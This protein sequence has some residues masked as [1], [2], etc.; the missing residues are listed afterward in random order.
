MHASFKSYVLSLKSFVYL[1]KYARVQT[2]TDLNTNQIYNDSEVV[3][4]KD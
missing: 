4:L 3:L 1:T 2:E